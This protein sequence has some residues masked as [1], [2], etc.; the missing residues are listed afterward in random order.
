MF[1]C[2]QY[3]HTN[4][5]AHTKCICIGYKQRARAPFVINFP[6]R[7][8]PLKSSE[9]S[10]C[11]PLMHSMMMR[12]IATASSTISSSVLWE[13][14]MWTVNF[15]TCSHLISS[16]LRHTVRAVLLYL[17]LNLG[18]LEEF[19]N[20]KEIRDTQTWLDYSQVTCIEKN[21]KTRWK[22]VAFG[23]FFCDIYCVK[24]S[25]HAVIHFYK[26]LVF[27]LLHVSILKSFHILYKNYRRL[28]ISTHKFTNKNIFTFYVESFANNR[29]IVTKF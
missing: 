16:I 23:D 14:F 4:S 5:S 13:N 22:C 9:I 24:K 19:V 20:L 12:A 25:F 21:W 10:K 3:T 1:E 2:Y 6:C 29:I 27:S 7:I 8:A 18:E 17:S 15:L 26:V 11:F 28:S